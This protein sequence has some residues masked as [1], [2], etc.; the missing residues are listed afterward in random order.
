MFSVEN[1]KSDENSSVLHHQHHLSVILVNE[2][3]VNEL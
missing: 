2:G 1:M 3:M